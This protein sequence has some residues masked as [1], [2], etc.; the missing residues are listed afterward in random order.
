MWKPAFTYI[1]FYS[2]CANVFFKLLLFTFALSLSDNIDV[3]LSA[4]SEPVL[5]FHTMF[6]SE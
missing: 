5:S 1:F 3:L 4:S 6:L 2:K